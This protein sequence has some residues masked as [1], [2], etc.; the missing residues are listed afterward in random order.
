MYMSASSCV[1]LQKDR[2]PEWQRRVGGGGGE[3][4]EKDVRRIAIPHVVQAPAESLCVC[5]GAHTRRNHDRNKVSAPTG[6]SALAGSARRHLSVRETKS[7]GRK[8]AHEPAFF[9]ENEPGFQ[10][11]GANLVTSSAQLWLPSDLRFYREKIQLQN[12]V[13][14]FYPLR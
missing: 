9:K 2:Q 11:V 13:S 8:D 7:H 1:W 10:Q 12:Q 4:R 6:V 14:H 5:A 3:Q